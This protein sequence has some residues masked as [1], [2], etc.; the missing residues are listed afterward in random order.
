M[1]NLLLA[2]TA[3]VAST[4]CAIHALINRKTWWPL[5]FL[6]FSIYFAL[7]MLFWVSV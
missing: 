1:I 4:M 2:V 7:A 5:T 3:F 6:G